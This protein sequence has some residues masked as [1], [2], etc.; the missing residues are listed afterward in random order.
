MARASPGVFEE[1][2]GATSGIR[3]ALSLHSVANDYLCLHES[4]GTLKDLTIAGFLY[5][6]N[7]S[8]SN[9]GGTDTPREHMNPFLLFTFIDVEPKEIRHG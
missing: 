1:A 5:L 4:S 8:Y 3:Q 7:I 2:V 9:L 6:I